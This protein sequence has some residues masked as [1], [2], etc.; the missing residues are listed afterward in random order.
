MEDIV[1]TSK[2][3]CRK[4]SEKSIFHIT[5]GNH[6]HFHQEIIKDAGDLPAS[7]LLP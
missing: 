7:L 1:Y 2:N 5:F 6:H 3:N 4:D